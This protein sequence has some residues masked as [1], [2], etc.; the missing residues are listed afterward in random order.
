MITT[1]LLF[2]FRNKSRGGSTVPPSDRLGLAS[3]QRTRPMPATTTITAHC[4]PTCHDPIWN[5]GSDSYTVNAAEVITLLEDL[6]EERY[7]YILLEYNN[8]I[9][10]GYGLDCD[11]EGWGTEYNQLTL[12]E[13]NFWRK[14]IG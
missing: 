9:T 11:P 7:A 8:Q 5:P 14:Y 2:R 4:I 6:K 12:S 3:H 13:I 10:V 1:I